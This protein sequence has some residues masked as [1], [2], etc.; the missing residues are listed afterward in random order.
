MRKKRLRLSCNNKSNDGKSK[1]DKLKSKY[2]L[3]HVNR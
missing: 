3:R 2:S 1:L